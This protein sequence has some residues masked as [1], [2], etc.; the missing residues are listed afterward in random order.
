[1]GMEAAPQGRRRKEERKKVGRRRGFM[2]EVESGQGVPYPI[3]MR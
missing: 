3:L 1:M 2:F